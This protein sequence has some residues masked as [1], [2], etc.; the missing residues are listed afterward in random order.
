MKATKAYIASLGTTGVL[1]GASILMLAIV[2]AVVAFDRWPDGTI[3]TRVQTLVISDAAAP[4]RVSAAA[5]GGPARA[6]LPG[7][8]GTSGRLRGVP[9][10]GFGFG[11]RPGAGGGLAAGPV[12]AAVNFLPSTGSIGLD[13]PPDPNSV[14]RQLADQSQSAAHAAGGSVGGIDPATGQA[15][16][17]AGQA[18]ADAV[19]LLPLPGQ[20][21]PGR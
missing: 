17:A 6:G 11:A 12:P 20:L 13:N 10:M 2:S 14:R 18:G 8:P 16:T 7:G 15:V 5:V 19:R 4:I 3:S 21:L 9:G 1:L